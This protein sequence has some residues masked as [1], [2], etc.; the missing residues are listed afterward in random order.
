MTRKEALEMTKKEALRSN[1]KKKAMT[2]EKRARRTADDETSGA[3]YLAYRSRLPRS[4][5]SVVRFIRRQ[6][7][8]ERTNSSTS[9]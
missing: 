2:A 1:D 6:D 3:L 7:K 4:M 8:Q 5:Q 9:E